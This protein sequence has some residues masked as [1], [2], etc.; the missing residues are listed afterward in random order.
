MMRSECV[1]MCK[2]L[3][4]KDKDNM[5]KYANSYIL[6]FVC[7]AGDRGRKIKISK[8]FK[9][10]SFLKYISALQVETC[11]NIIIL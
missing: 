5:F 1:C 3:C 4:G 7:S 9:V 2:Y 11:M 6:K 10:I 8:Y